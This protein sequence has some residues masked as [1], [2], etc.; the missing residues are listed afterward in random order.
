M[1]SLAIN[2]GDPSARLTQ[3]HRAI[4]HEP[5]LYLAQS[6]YVTSSFSMAWISS[7]TIDVEEMIFRAD[8]ALYDPKASGRIRI[9]FDAKPAQSDGNRA[10]FSN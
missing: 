4:L 1:P 9:T 6:I 7:E 10:S 5:F 3:L 2:K 8:E